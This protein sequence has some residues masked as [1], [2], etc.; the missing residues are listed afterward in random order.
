MNVRSTAMFNDAAD[1][2]QTAQKINEDGD[3]DP[4]TRAKQFD[5]KF[6]EYE[7]LKKRADAELANEAKLKAA[8]DEYAARNVRDLDD[9]EPNTST[10]PGHNI[11]L[12]DPA[13]ARDGVLIM[14][15]KGGQRVVP[16]AD[17]KTEGWV[18]SLPA[19]CQHPMIVARLTPKLQEE[20]KF[21]QDVFIKYIRGGKDAMGLMSKDELKAL[22]EGTDTEGGFAVP[23]DQVRLPFIHDAG[24]EGGTIRR[25]ASVFQTTR[26]SGDWPTITTVSWTWTAEEAALSESDPVFGQEAF[27][28]F[29]A[30]GLTKVSAELIEDS[31][32]P[33]A[34]LLG[35]LY[36]E[37]LGQEE[38]EQF[39]GGDG[40][41][42]PEGIRTNG[43]VG[44]SVA[45]YNAS[46]SPDND[47]IAE[48]YTDLP[49]RFR[50]NG[51]WHTT[52]SFLRHLL[53]ITGAGVP[54]VVEFMGDPVV[55]RILGR[56]MEFFDG[57]G[58]DDAGAIAVNEEFGVFGDFR[59]YYVIDRVGMSIRRLDELYAAND[60]IGFVARVRETGIVGLPAGFKI[61][62]AAAA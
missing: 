62:K 14:D 16:F 22:Q 25:L 40:S 58:W 2:L 45:D 26:D 24:V 28:I 37:S 46:T 6:D 20:A 57:T 43:A 10:N 8:T 50:R 54:R 52:S 29:K 60:Q 31:A 48:H 13:L 35:Q 34:A 39:I 33:I 5:G 53:S 19:A 49:A 27:T 32:V 59:H 7:V 47:D 61:L 17:G 18:K 23:S 44:D 51:T 41:V 21:Y 56:P 3:L 4:E 15:K 9:G 38:D 55:P 1:L 36:T 42:E 12:L 11:K 30:A